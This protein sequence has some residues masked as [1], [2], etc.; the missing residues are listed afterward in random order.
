MRFEKNNKLSTGRPKNAL[1]KTTAEA[2][3]LLQKIVNNELET[4][5]E[6][7]ETLEPKERLD[8]VIKLLPYVLPRQTEIALE[9]KMNQFTPVTVTLLENGNTD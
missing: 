5:A 2:K 8:A 9:A 4:V 3:A 1:N 6:L 7:L